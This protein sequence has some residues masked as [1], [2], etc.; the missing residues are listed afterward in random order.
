LKKTHHKKKAGGV[1]KVKAL[2][3]NPSTGKRERERRRERER[4][5]EKITKVGLEI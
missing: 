2:S 5:G 1:V 3:S 4:E